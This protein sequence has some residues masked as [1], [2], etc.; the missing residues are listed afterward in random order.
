MSLNAELFPT[1]NNTLI[2]NDKI[3]MAELGGVLVGDELVALNGLSLKRF[4]LVQF[5]SE[6]TAARIGIESGRFVSDS[7]SG[8]IL[9]SIGETDGIVLMFRRKILN[10]SF[11]PP[12]VFSIKYASFYFS[13]ELPDFLL[14]SSLV[15]LDLIWPKARKNANLEA[16]NPLNSSESS[17]LLCQLQV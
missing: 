4:S 9:F 7:S 1:F 5:T 2:G 11:K 15:P 12:I 10:S 16:G 3:S 8:I 13:S 17:Q 6:L 14:D